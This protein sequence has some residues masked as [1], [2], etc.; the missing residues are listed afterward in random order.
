MLLGVALFGG[1]YVHLAGYPTDGAA[2]TAGLSGVYALAAMRGR[3]SMLSGGWFSVRGAVRAV[4]IGVAS[5]NTVAGSYVFMTG[6]REKDRAARE[7]A[8]RWGDG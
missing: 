8:N 1:T 3:P 7:Q 4:S 6:N 5:V 2:Y